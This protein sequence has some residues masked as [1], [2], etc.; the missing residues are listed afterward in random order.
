VG[1]P[2]HLLPPA[3]EAATG[4]AAGASQITG[5]LPV[6]HRIL[7]V[8]HLSITCMLRPATEAATGTAAGAS[9]LTG[10]RGLHEG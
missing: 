6:C 9:Q 2:H 4:T 1:F 10:N 8:Y 5:V 7:P 3:A